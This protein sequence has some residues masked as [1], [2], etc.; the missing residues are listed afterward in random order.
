[1]LPRDPAAYQQA[2]AQ[3]QANRDYLRQRGW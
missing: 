3:Q 2:S 1:V